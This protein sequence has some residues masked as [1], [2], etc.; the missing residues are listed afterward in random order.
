MIPSVLPPSR[1]ATTL[2]AP[3]PDDLAALRAAA[4][5]LPGHIDGHGL[6]ALDALRDVR[7]LI[8]S[9]EHH[10]PFLLVW[11]DDYE[12]LDANVV[13]HTPHLPNSEWMRR[14][15]LVSLANI[16]GAAKGAAL[17]LMER[18]EQMHA[19]MERG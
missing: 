3:P 11:L 6:I 7:R 8:L 5:E 15:L 10:A 4:R 18:A 16:A 14:R 17:M 2:P 19:H 9:G 12:C 1:P 13:V